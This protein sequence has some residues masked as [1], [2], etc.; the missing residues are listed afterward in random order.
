MA[1]TLLRRQLARTS[2]RAALFNLSGPS[3]SSCKKRS[4]ASTSVLRQAE[5]V[6][7]E[8]EYRQPPK[9]LLDVHTVE[10]LQTMTPAE[11]LA[12]TGTKRSSQMRHFT[13]IV[14][15]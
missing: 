7:H 5:P 9:S 2:P 10:D 4:L 12:E 11:V 13:G 3:S 1:S 6:S 15:F 14:D 8:A